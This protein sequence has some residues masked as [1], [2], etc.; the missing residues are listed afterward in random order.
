MVGLRWLALLD[1][2]ICNNT[3]NNLLQ[4]SWSPGVQQSDTNRI[5][6]GRAIQFSVGYFPR[7]VCATEGSSV[8]RVCWLFF[9]LCKEFG[10]SFRPVSP[11]VVDT[12]LLLL[13]GPNGCIMGDRDCAYHLLT[14]IFFFPPYLLEILIYRWPTRRRRQRLPT[15]ASRTST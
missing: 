6:C 14:L 4:T 1:I 15:G 11:K 5:S 13:V 9:L 2:N 7:F 10:P 3:S 8:S 12:K